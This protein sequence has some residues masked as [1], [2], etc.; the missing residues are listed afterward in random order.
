MLHDRN[1]VTGRGHKSWYSNWIS[2]TIGACLRCTTDGALVLL[3]WLFNS[4]PARWGNTAPLRA[5][6]VCVCVAQLTVPWHC[7]VSSLTRSPPG[8]QT[9]HPIRACQISEEDSSCSW[10]GPPPVHGCCVQHRGDSSPCGQSPMDFES[11]PLTA[12][13]QCHVTLR[14]KHSGKAAVLMRH[15]S[16]HSST[17]S[18]AHARTE[19][20]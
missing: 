5:P 18:D 4:L 3:R 9:P 12:R 20:R 6:L 14:I 11:I 15:C 2:T 8:E 10:C 16:H 17:R 13:A 7:F 19:Q 1:K